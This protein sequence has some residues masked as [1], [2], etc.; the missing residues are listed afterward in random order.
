[1][2]A[3]VTTGSMPFHGGAVC[4]L[5]LDHHPEIVAARVHA[6]R[7]VEDV[8]DVTRRVDVQREPDIHLRILE[9]ALLHHELRP[10]FLTRRC[11]FFGRLE[12]ELDRSRQFVL[13][14]GKHFGDPHEDGHVRIVSTRVHDTNVLPVVR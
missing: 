14:A 12:H 5:P 9:D 4:L 10:A 13:H 6:P 8:A 11:T 2:C 1:M 7:C 3:L